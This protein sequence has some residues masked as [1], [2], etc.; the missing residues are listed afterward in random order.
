[1][2]RSARG[3]QCCEG[4]LRAP[5]VVPGPLRRANPQMED[6]EKRHDFA[7]LH[8]SKLRSDCAFPSDGPE[9]VPAVALIGYARV[10]IT[11]EETWRQHDVLQEAGCARIFTDRASGA[12]EERPELARALDHLREGDTLVVWR[13]DRLARSLRDLV[14]T[15]AALGRARHHAAQPGREDRHGGTRAGRI[16]C[17]SARACRP[18]SSTS[19]ASA[20]RAG[21]AR[22]SASR[23]SNDD[24]RGRPQPAALRRD[25]RRRG[26]P[27]SARCPAPAD[28]PRR[29]PPERAARRAGAARATAPASRC[30]SSPRRP[31][32]SRPSTSRISDAQGPALSLRHTAANADVVL[33]YPDDWRRSSSDL[34]VADLGL[35]DPIVLTP[36]R[37]G[38]AM[39]MAGMSPATGATLLPG[40]VTR[41]LSQTPAPAR[42][43]LGRL[44][45]YHYAD[46]RV[47]GLTRRHDGLRRADERG[48]A[49]DGVPGAVARRPRPAR[50]GLRSAWRS[51]C[52]SSAAARS[53]SARAAATSSTSTSSSRRWTA[54][55]DRPARRARVGPLAGRAG[56]H[57][58][59]AGD[60]V[61]PRPGDRRPRS[62]PRRA[63]PPPTGGILAAIDAGASRLPAARAGRQHRQRRA[64]R[65]RADRGAPRRAPAA[66]PRSAR[67]R[68]LGYETTR[69]A[70]RADRDGPPGRR[71]GRGDDPC[72]ADVA[73]HARHR[74]QRDVR[75]RA[76]PSDRRQGAA[77]RRHPRLG[78][79]TAAARE[80]ARPCRRAARAAPGAGRCVRRARVGSPSPSPPARRCAPR[81]PA[82][83]AAARRYSESSSS[84]SG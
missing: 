13:L 34:A 3:P 18:S 24:R 72:R 40:G 79:A 52:A 49:D 2:A 44:R 80:H 28:A 56:P 81:P 17:T 31:P 16:S 57:R 5:F 1:M 43:K 15:V 48:R 27:S 82:A 84:T 26:R 30:R 23:A 12:H 69:R 35:D 77:A 45:A 78:R 47:D 36:G 54:T 32:P 65:R 58:R 7:Q 10:S 29:R 39:I 83:D 76:R 25:A 21:R 75:R 42:V 6:T 41:R 20:A 50:R 73:Q 8:R 71:P 68:Q 33:R 70:G 46:L 19:S 51:R 38:G 4:R 67:S 74:L 60:G 14:D 61:R 55:P 63:R 37:A 22:A 66:A 9:T 62:G 11:E 53:R 59:D 64:L